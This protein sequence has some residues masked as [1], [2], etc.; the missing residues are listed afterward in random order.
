MITQY[1]PSFIKDLKGLKST[2]YYETIRT[3]AFEEIPR[4]LTFEEI[5][6]LKKL[7]GYENAYCIR[8]GDYR[9][10][11]IFDGETVLFQRVLHRKDIYRYFPK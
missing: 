6:N 10:G 3:L 7:Q 1:L 11:L 5:T 8:F 2:P 9:I 4:I